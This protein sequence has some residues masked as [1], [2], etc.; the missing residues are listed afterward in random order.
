MV[1]D[2]LEMKFEDEFWYTGVVLS[3]VSTPGRNTMSV[4]FYD[5]EVLSRPCIVVDDVSFDPLDPD[6]NWSV[7]PTRPR[8]PSFILILPHAHRDFPT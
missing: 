1:G 2:V 7:S 8:L 4:K 3:T 5:G 6:I